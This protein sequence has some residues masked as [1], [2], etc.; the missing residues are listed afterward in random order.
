[1]DVWVNDKCTVLLGILLPA[2]PMLPALAALTKRQ[3]AALRAPYAVLPASSVKELRL[4][5]TQDKLDVVKGAVTLEKPAVL[6]SA[7]GSEWFATTERATLQLDTS[8]LRT[9]MSLQQAQP[10]RP[11]IRR[12][13]HQHMDLVHRAP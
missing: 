7:V 12:M 6:T 5:A 3:S 8:L 9:A 1:M 4:V 11:Q 2:T 13:S 10:L